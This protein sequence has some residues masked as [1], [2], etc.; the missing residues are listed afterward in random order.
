MK[1]ALPVSDMD[2]HISTSLSGTVLVYYFSLGSFGI[3]TSLTNDFQ[4]I[5]KG[6]KS[7]ALNMVIKLANINGEPCI[8]ISDELTKVGCSLTFY[9]SG[10]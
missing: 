8:K 6:S 2:V 1:S 4:S 7:K 9:K 5:T 10:G 3:G